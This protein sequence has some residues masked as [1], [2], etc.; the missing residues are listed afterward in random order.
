M[1]WTESDFLEQLYISPEWKKILSGYL[2]S[3]PIQHQDLSP[4]LHLELHGL[5]MGKDKTGLLVGIIIRLFLLCPDQHC[6][7]Y[8]QDSI[9]TRLTVHHAISRRETSAP[10]VLIAA[11]LGWLAQTF[12]KS[13]G[14]GFSPAS[15]HLAETC[16]SIIPV[17]TL[18]C[19]PNFLCAYRQS[20]SNGE[21]HEEALQQILGYGLYTAFVLEDLLAP[22]KGISVMIDSMHIANYGMIVEIFS[23]VA[24]ILAGLKDRWSLALEPFTVRHAELLFSACGRCDMIQSQ[25][26]AISNGGL[27]QLLIALQHSLKSF[28]WF[29]EN[30]IHALHAHA[31]SRRLFLL[32][33]QEDNAINFDHT[34]QLSVKVS[35]L[36]LCGW[37]VDHAEVRNKDCEGTESSPANYLNNSSGGPLDEDAMPGQP[38]GT[39]SFMNRCNNIPK[40]EEGSCFYGTYPE[41]I[42]KRLLYAPERKLRFSELHAWFL[43]YTIKSKTPMLKQSLRNALSVSP[44]FKLIRAKSNGKIVLWWY[45]TDTGVESE[46][47]RKINGQEMIQ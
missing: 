18:N 42:C 41:L 17:P 40:P 23:D 29:I 2:S 37:R 35:Q 28:V 45:L 19:A 26:K 39:L 36:Q 43:E 11:I 9:N 15:I 32:A 10:G 5:L 21:G 44:C 30:V 4:D 25:A 22:M 27:M 31:S 1:D 47:E 6:S 38:S 3:N 20:R 46:K 16:F 33:G 12:V 13:P 14:P 8:V 24:N 34:R 7:L